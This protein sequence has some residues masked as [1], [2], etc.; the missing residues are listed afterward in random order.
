MRKANMFYW[1]SALTGAF[2]IAAAIGQSPDATIKAESAQ[3]ES[4]SEGGL[5]VDKIACGVEIANRELQGQDT[6]FAEST[7]KVYCWVTILGGREGTIVNFVWYHDDKEV[8]KVPIAVNYSRTR[9]WSY[10]SMY[11]GAKGNWRVEVIDS[12]NQVMGST[13]FKVQ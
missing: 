7:E 2:I 8:A 6:V 3:T 4:T 11:P 10:K 5:K 12:N 9:T 13:S 1:V